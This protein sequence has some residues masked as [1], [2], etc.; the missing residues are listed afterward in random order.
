[1]EENPP[2]DDFVA[3]FLFPV[4][5]FLFLFFVFFNIIKKKNDHIALS[6]QLSAYQDSVNVLI[7]ENKKLHAAQMSYSDAIVNAMMLQEVEHGKD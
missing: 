5:L 1:M 4:C 3:F 2:L 6:A 7:Q